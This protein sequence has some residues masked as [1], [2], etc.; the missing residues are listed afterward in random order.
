MEDCTKEIQHTKKRWHRVHKMTVAARRVL[1]QEIVSLFE[2]KPGVVEDSPAITIEPSRTISSSSSS[3]STHT[4][5]TI[6]SPTLPFAQR[7]R[8]L[9]L[10][11]HH[12]PSTHPQQHNPQQQQQAED[13]YI[14]GVTLPARVIDVSKYSKEELNA[15][16]GHLIHM[17]GLIIRYLGVKLPF[18]IYYKTMYPYIRS[19]IAKQRNSSKMP[20][21]LDDKNLRR[22]TIGMAM[23]N[24][25]IA[26][27]CHTQGVEIPLSQVTNA[28]QALMACCRS[29]RLGL[30]SH[31]SLYQGIR[32][33]DF[34][35]EF[36]QVLKMTA[37]RYRSGSPM[38]SELNKELVL[39]GLLQQQPQQNNA[40][41]WYYYDGLLDN[42]EDDIQDDEEDY[43]DDEG[44][45]G[46]VNSENWN[47]VDVMPSFGRPNGEGESIFQLGATIM[48]GVIGMSRNVIGNMMASGSSSSQDHHH[49]HH[50]NTHATSDNQEQQQQQELQ[51]TA[52]EQNHLQILQQ[53]PYYYRR[54]SAAV[55][56]NGFRFSRPLL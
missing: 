10:H 11:R 56:R 33:I 39:N 21:F 8:S 23:L 44:V 45:E 5:A 22:F 13:L 55:K 37:L 17:L 19:T 43:D 49:S 46:G 16:I 47:L 35:L 24:Y 18:P 52:L 1:V 54:L 14:C 42:S 34:P 7:D 51:P 50:N 53:Y 6:M 41:D 40:D 15:A 25:D 27:L 3:S 36:H 26:Y 12:H 32:S 30:R 28:L 31:I 48:P 29:Q 4:N 38:T 9:S 20:L 2:F